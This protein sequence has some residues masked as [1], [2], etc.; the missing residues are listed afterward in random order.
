[1]AVLVGVLSWGLQPVINDNVSLKKLNQELGDRYEIPTQMPFVGD[2]QCYI[3]YNPQHKSLRFEVNAKKATGY[4]IEC[5][6]AKRN[7]SI[8]TYGLIPSLDGQEGV[9]EDTYKN[10]KVWYRVVKNQNIFVIIVFE[11]NNHAYEI[12]AEYD[13]SVE[14]A[15]MQADIEKVMSQIIK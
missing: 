11:A 15:T 9:V 14:Q 13:Q 8:L 2:T 5:K 4:L 12:K 6:D 3:I 7:I 1:M 10:Q